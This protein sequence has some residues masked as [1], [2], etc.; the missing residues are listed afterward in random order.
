MS[1][2]IQDS[3][4]ERSCYMKDKTMTD[5]LLICKGWYNKKLYNNTLEAFNAY[6]HKYYGCEDIT[7]DKAFAEYLFLR[8]LALK[9]IEIKPVLARYIFDPIYSA[10]DNKKPFSETMYDR[11]IGLI[12][13]IEKGMFDLSEYDDMFMKAKECNY[14]DETIGII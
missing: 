10:I 11:L 7:M 13:M 6:Y 1:R 14:E 4:R 3:I 5:I 12:Q 8:P 2:L 9:A